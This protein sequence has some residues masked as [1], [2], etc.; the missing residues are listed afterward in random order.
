MFKSL[1]D[2]YISYI[3]KEDE[4][5]KSLVL[6]E[7]LITS[8][9][10]DLVKQAIGKKSWSEYMKQITPHILN[11]NL[12]TW[13]F[14]EESKKELE[15][16]CNLYGYF[17]SRIDLDSVMP[18][19]EIEAKYPQKLCDNDLPNTLLHVAPTKYIDNIKK[20][21]LTPKNTKRV[22]FNHPGNR[23]YLCTNY[24]DLSRLA[25]ALSRGRPADEQAQTTLAVSVSDLDTHEFFV[26]PQYDYGVFTLKNIP[27][28]KIQ[29]LG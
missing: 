9:P 25:K 16:I 6:L 12:K 7:G 1:F 22:K 23:I 18:H 29:F 19:V 5:N 21:G 2:E 11:I 15:Q 20:I 3:I 17:I 10:I 24:E 13:K 28:D 14:S 26:D 8:Y 4:D 27:P